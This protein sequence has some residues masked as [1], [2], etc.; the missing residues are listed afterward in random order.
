MLPKIH[1]KKEIIDHIK[2]SDQ[3]FVEMLP[4]KDLTSRP[5]IAGPMSPTQRLSE[6]L[7]TIKTTGNKIENIH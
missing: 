3:D 5:I 7:D 6:I 2:S 1:K 4:P